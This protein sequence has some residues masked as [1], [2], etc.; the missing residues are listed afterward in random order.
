M[1]TSTQMMKMNRIMK[2]NKIKMILMMKN[3][4]VSKVIVSLAI[5]KNNRNL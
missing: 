1:I 3:K 2:I 4:R 5:T